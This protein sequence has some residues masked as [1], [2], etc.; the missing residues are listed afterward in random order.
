M[1]VLL[2]FAILI[3]GIVYATVSVRREAKRKRQAWIREKYGAE[4]KRMEKVPDRIRNYCETYCGKQTV[5]E[6]TWNDLNMDEVFLEIDNCDSSMGEEVLYAWLHDTARGEEDF[7]LLE[8]QIDYVETHEEERRELETLLSDL[9]KGEASC[10]IP[11]YAQSME[12]FRIPHIWIY[13]VLQ[14]LLL[15]GV[16][17]A[18]A[19]LVL[20]NAL[21]VFLLGAVFVC[22]IIVYVLTVKARHAEPI[23]MLGTM[24]YLVTVSRKLY[25]RFRGTGICEELGE[26]LPEFQ[27]MDRKAFLLG[28]QMSRAN[29]DGLEA[30]QDLLVGV[31]MWHILTYDKLMKQ[32]SGQV[33]EYMELYR[34]VGGLDAAVSV[35]SFRRRLPHWCRPEYTDRRVL[36]MEEVYHP[37]LRD[38]VCNSVTL[39]HSCIITGSNASG[40]STFIKA[41]AVNVILGQSI[42][43]CMAKRMALPRARMITS[44]AV[45]DD[46]LSGESYFIK[47]IRYLKRILDELSE[48]ETLIC[49]VDEI[50]RGT[51][52]LERIAASR[53]ILEY[54]RERNCIAIVASHDRELT[55]LEAI[56]YENY[57]FTE[58]IGQ[59]DISFDYV[60]RRGPADSRNAI[61]LLEFAGFPEEVVVRARQLARE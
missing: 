29:G 14:L 50:L 8:R 52:T 21:G 54:L 15:A 39:E 4:P 49:V 1:E 58:N 60:L 28:N 18:V 48:E 53:A 19:G 41:V 3:G 51:N 6:V 42:H 33:G 59:E 23:R 47:E 55:E 11:S 44:M 30:F 22:N 36:R 61:R 32:L 31:T 46:I 45:R 43:T 37:L 9:G 16:L 7:D 38:P 17:S 25:Q 27:G 34:I 2:V 57:H 56:G 35:G 5:D 40:K 24:L 13:R 20:G 10:Y 26:Y 12:D